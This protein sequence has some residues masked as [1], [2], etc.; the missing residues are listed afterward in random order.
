LKA[1]KEDEEGETDEEYL[2]EVEA[3]MVGVGVESP[4]AGMKEDEV[5]I[6]GGK[7]FRKIQ[8]RVYVIDGDEF[9]TEDDPKGDQKIDKWGNL[10]GG[11]SMSSFLLL[12]P[13]T[14]LT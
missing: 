10:L 7:P 5:P 9:I 8:N 2:P 14:D 1:P 12:K 13:Y 6:G 3:P 11:M 4:N